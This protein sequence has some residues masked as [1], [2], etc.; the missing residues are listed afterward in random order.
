M[1][2][3]IE[4][5]D[6]LQTVTVLAII[7]L[8]Y[9]VRGIVGFGSGLI[10]VPLLVFF[11]P[12]TVV[13]PLVVLLDYIASATH[14]IH[15]RR[16]IQWRELSVV[17]PFSLIGVLVALYVLRQFELEHLLLALGIF[18][19]SYG[20]YS[21]SPFTPK[22][23]Y[24][25][26][27]GIPGGLLAGLVGTLFATG[28]PFYVTYLHLRQLDKTA[29][30]ASFATLFLID[31]AARLTGFVVGGFYNLDLLWLLALSLPTMFIGLYLGGHIHTSLPATMFQRLISV[32]LL[33]SGIA[34][35][36]R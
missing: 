14:G 2:P 36:L 5:L 27:W 23:R 30:R 20:L 10:C 26:L 3:M 29:F 35:V 1:D 25:R 21:L 32:L 9:V 16:H 19:I 22:R 4:Q 8:A 6:V 31:G 15:N 11:L 34:L 28:G 18:L 33:V 17:L 7:A 24:S 13:V 12:L